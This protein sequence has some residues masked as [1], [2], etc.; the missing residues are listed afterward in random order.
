[1]YEIEHNIPVPRKQER[2]YPFHQMK[3]GDSFFIPTKSKTEQQSKRRAAIA[4]ARKLKM[5]ITSRAMDSGVRI[6]RIA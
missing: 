6:W 3:K 1:M 4:S 5:K 2:I